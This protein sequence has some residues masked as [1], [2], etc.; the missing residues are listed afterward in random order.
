MDSGAEVRR[1]LLGD[2]GVRRKIARVVPIA[3]GESIL[4]N[5]GPLGRHADLPVLALTPARGTTTGL[6]I[7][8][9][10]PNPDAGTCRRPHPR[11]SEGSMILGNPED[12][13]PP[14]TARYRPYDVGEAWCAR[15]RGPLTAMR[16]PE[17]R[18][19]D[20]GGSWWSLS[21]RVER[22]LM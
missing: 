7:G 8:S 18:S 1:S 12:V 4:M 20:L 2:A 14:E 21:P 15:R 13:V 22:L 3:S 16:R 17:G 9:A 6:G 5:A 19:L 10:Q 11:P